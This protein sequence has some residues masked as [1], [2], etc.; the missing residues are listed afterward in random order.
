[1][2][3]EIHADPYISYFAHV[4][5][6]L[7]HQRLIA[8]KALP[9]D[10][11]KVN[12]FRPDLQFD[13]YYYRDERIGNNPFSLL[14][15]RVYVGHWYRSDQDPEKVYLKLKSDLDPPNDF[16]YTYDMDIYGIEWFLVPVK[17]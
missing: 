5:L 16:S 17:D 3:Q 10:K 15:D 7:L 14:K 12:S 13:L 2:Y 4:R 1:M 6:W 8:L 11:V 9:K